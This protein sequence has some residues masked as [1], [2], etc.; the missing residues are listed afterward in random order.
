MKTE[1]LYY[2]RTYL[3]EFDATVVSVKEGDGTHW[4]TEL[5]RSAFY[6]TSG[7]Q[8]FDTGRIG[9]AFVS[10][11]EVD[12]NGTVFHYTDR[13]FVPGDRVKGTIDWDRRFD[14]MQQH[15]GEH[16]LAGAIWEKVHGTTIGLHLGDTVSSIDVTMPDGRTHL[17]RE[18]ITQIEKLVNSRI[19]HDDAI[20]CW[21]PADDELAALPLRKEPTVKENIRIVQIGEYETVACGGTHPSTTGQI[22]SIYITDVSPARGK[23]R[24]SF[25]CG[26]RAAKLYRKTGDAADEACRLLS[27]SIETLPKEISRILEHQEKILRELRAAQTR[28][29]CV[30]LAN[31]ETVYT[32]DFRLYAVYEP[33]FDYD[34]ASDAVSEWIRSQGRIV[35]FSNGKRLIYAASDD[36]N[37]DMAALMKK[38]A[39]GGGRKDFAT[40]AGGMDE[41]RKAKDELAGT[42]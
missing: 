39:R 8:P 24:F 34:A 14:H 20:R 21:F 37:A 42:K 5:D 31:A 32:G 36:V 33:G 38:T 26:A 41:I 17:S 28:L 13:C 3:R 16:M 7:G 9:E 27:S 10:N 29:L 25:V 35:L 2:N 30:R 11:V 6:P 1:R 23:I 40:G 12:K 4:W 15:A 19:Q 22:G 18:E